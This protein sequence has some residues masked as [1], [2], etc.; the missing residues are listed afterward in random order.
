[1][2]ATSRQRQ[3]RLRQDTIEAGIVPKGI[4]HGIQFQTAVGETKQTQRWAGNQLILGSRCLRGRKGESQH[5][6]S[7]CETT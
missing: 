4:P 2:L 6:V 7:D 5:Y 1:M 3:S